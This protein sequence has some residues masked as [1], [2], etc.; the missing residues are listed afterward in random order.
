MAEAFILRAVALLLICVACRMR[1]ILVFSLNASLSHTRHSSRHVP[2]S[3]APTVGAGHPAGP[4]YRLAP[5]PCRARRPRRATC[6]ALRISPWAAMPSP[7]H[8]SVYLRTHRRGRT[9]DRPAAP[10]STAP[11]RARRPRR[12]DCTAPPFV[13]RDA[14][15]APLAHGFFPSADVF[16]WSMPATR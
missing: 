14:H 9:P 5:H 7:R 1:A 2:F 6:T 11:C 10:F 16:T 3:S 8:V 4:L 12:A 13:G 15:I